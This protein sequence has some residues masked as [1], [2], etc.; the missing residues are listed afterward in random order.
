MKVGELGRKTGKSVR[1][2]RLYEEMGLLTPES[3]SKGG[4]R[5]YSADQVARVYWIAKLQ[6]MGFGLAQIRELLSAVEASESAP[7]AMHNVR[8]MFRA[9]LDQTRAHVAKL[10]ELERDLSESLAYLEGC[11]ACSEAAAPDACASCDSDHADRHDTPAPSLV[12]GIH[13]QNV[14]PDGGEIVQ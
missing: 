6:D 5:L 8:E 12:A 2:I 11:R 3:R 13:I 7:G 10:L 9:R 1:A 4:F 14:P